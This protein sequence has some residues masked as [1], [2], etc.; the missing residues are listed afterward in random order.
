MTTS[1]SSLGADLVAALAGQFV[2]HR[3]IL[4]LTTPVGPDALLAESLR[5]SE[6][7]QRTV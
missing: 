1:F 5:A 7:N 4:R 6:G 2:Q 3:R